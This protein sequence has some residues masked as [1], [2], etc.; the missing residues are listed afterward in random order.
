MKANKISGKICDVKTFPLERKQRN[1]NY[2]QK[3]VRSQQMKQ[4]ENMKSK[5]KRLKDESLK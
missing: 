2:R 3:Y 1:K 4:T 5:K